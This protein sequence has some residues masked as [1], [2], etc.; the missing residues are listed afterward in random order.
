MRPTCRRDFRR[1]RREPARRRSGQSLAGASEPALAA[2]GPD[3]HLEG[4]RHQPHGVETDDSRT[5]SA[6]VAGAR[7]I[8]QYEV[9]GKRHYN[10]IRVFGQTAGGGRSPEAEIA[11]RSPRSQSP[12]STPP[13]VPISPSSNRASRARRSGCRAPAPRSSGS[14]SPPSSGACRRSP[15]ANEIGLGGPAPPAPRERAPR[16]ERGAGSSD[17]DSVV[18]G[19]APTPRRPSPGLPRS[20]PCPAVWQSDRLSR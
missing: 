20:P 6:S 7:L 18:S 3:H 9:E 10:D 13:I 19:G 11:A 14:A 4:D 2:G 15:E 16:E 8:Y 1:H 17:N 5:M 12:S